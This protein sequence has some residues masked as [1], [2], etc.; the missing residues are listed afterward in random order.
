MSNMIWWFTGVVTGFGILS[1][2]IIGG[3]IWFDKAKRKKFNENPELYEEY[4]KWKEDQHETK[5]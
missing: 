2:I 1:A 3:T 4:A 5:H